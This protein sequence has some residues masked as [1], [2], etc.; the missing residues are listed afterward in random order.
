MSKERSLFRS[1]VFVAIENERGE[2]LL[3][4]RGKTG[5][6]DG[7]WDLSATGHLEYDESCDECGVRE[8]LE[9]TGLHIVPDDMMLHAI[10]QSNFEPGVHYL[11]TIFRCKRWSGEVASGEPEKIIDLQ[12]FK[13]ER[14]PDK[15]TVGARVYVMSRTNTTVKNYYVGRTEFRNMMGY[16]YDN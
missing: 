14:F 12:W 7:Y 15:L 6:L 16:D 13:P 3:Q 9:E 11:N 2:I 8:V 4:R 10:F 1:A 5:F